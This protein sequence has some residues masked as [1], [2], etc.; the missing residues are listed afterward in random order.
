MEGFLANYYEYH[1]LYITGIHHVESQEHSGPFPDEVVLPPGHEHGPGD[2]GNGE[3]RQSCPGLHAAEHGIAVRDALRYG[4][5]AGGLPRPLQRDPQHRRNPGPGLVPGAADVRQPAGRLRAAALRRQPA[6]GGHHRRSATPAG[7]RHDAR[8]TSSVP[9]PRATRSAPPAT[10]P[11]TASTLSFRSTRWSATFATWKR[12]LCEAGRKR[13]C[14]SRTWDTSR[15]VP[16]LPRAMPWPTAA[17][18]ST[19]WS[20]SGPMP[21]P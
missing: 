11:W 13:P 21:R 3:L 12:S 14:T 9:W 7:L 18:P 15:T 2:G 19:S 17:G 20:P 8:T 16:M 5:R 6:D 1:F 10:F 4:Q